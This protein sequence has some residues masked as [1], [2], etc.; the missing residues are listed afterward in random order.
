VIRVLVV[1]AHALLRKAI[2]SVTW[3]AGLED[4]ALEYDEAATQAEGLRALDRKPHA[5]IIDPVLGDPDDRRGM[6]IVR[7]AHAR[8]IPV[9]V[10]TAQR[11]E[12]SIQRELASCNI[13]ILTK[14][15]D[16]IILNDMAVRRALGIDVPVDGSFDT[17]VRIA[18]QI[19]GLPGRLSENIKKLLALAIFSA[20]AD[21]K[22]NKS[23]AA[24]LIGERR[25]YIDRWLAY[26]PRRPISQ[27]RPRVDESTAPISASI[28]AGRS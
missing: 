18:S 2:A 10:H 19:R 5:V 15:V 8:G 1:D 21:A 13:P 4:V 28:Q 11:L 23:A 12:D 27:A 14:S 20:L 26:L 3:L 25:T 9:L 6:A 16:P 24:Q 17:L 7:A 22:G